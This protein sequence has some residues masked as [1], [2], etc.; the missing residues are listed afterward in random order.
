[1]VLDGPPS[2]KRP[3]PNEATKDT[4]AEGAKAK[5]TRVY[6]PASALNYKGN[7]FKKNF[8][9]RT[10]VLF[11]GPRIALFWTSGDVSSGFQS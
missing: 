7:F 2:P 10:Q 6:V 8:F 3:R 1:M 11:V 9:W 4:E 5:K